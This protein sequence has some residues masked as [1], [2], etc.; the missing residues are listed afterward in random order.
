MRLI[1]VGVDGM[2]TEAL[3]QGPSGAIAKGAGATTCRSHPRPRGSRGHSPL[4][5]GGLG[6]VKGGARSWDVSG[7]LEALANTVEV[8]SGVSPSSIS[9]ALDTETIRLSRR[10]LS[11]LASPVLLTFGEPSDEAVARRER[12]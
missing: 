1:G 9:P 2:H 10:R 7:D 12:R 5:T 6:G 4:R 8:V 3:R 11:T